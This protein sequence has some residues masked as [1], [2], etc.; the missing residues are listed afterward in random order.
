MLSSVLRILL[1]ATDS[2]S[3]NYQLKPYVFYYLHYE[4]MLLIISTLIW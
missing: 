2:Q 1:L 3:Q 4:P